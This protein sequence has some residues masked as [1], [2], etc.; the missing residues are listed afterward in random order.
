M[1]EIKAGQIWLS[2][3]N[4]KEPVRV[5][6]I[7]DEYDETFEDVKTWVVFYWYEKGEYVEDCDSPKGFL[8][9]FN[10]NCD[11]C[12]ER[13]FKQDIIKPSQAPIKQSEPVTASD[14]KEYVDK[15]DMPVKQNK[16]IQILTEAIE[17]MA[18]RGKTYDKAGGQERSMGKTVA[19]FNALT[20]HSLT[21]EQ[22]WA[23]MAILKLARSQQGEYKADN[24]LD[25]TAYFAL[26]GEAAEM[27]RGQCQ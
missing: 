18:E 5:K 21:E 9:R 6:R 20:G 14:T 2:N 24:Y 23:F 25:G 19:A 22:G 17:V 13:L 10:F 4:K 1:Q 8:E 26:M 12:D 15:Y 7:C 11:D 3:D 16:A 27:E